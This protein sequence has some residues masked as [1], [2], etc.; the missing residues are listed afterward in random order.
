MPAPA[1]PVSAALDYYETVGQNWER[2]AL[3]KARPCAGDLPRA[4]TF[5]AELTPFIWR[6]NLDFSAIEDIQSIKLPVSTSQVSTFEAE[7]P[8]LIFA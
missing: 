5:L 2:A 8:I 7:V 1:A 6:R 3:I 4:R